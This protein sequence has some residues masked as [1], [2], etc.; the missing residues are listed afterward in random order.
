MGAEVINIK[1]LQGISF[2][3]LQRGGKC[4]GSGR[5]EG[6]STHHRCKT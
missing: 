2:T 1:E 4:Y 3:N 6:S 5:E